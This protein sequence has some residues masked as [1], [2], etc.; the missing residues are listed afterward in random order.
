LIPVLFKWDNEIPVTSA[1]KTTTREKSRD[2]KDECV[3][4]FFDIFNSST[5]DVT[6]FLIEEDVSVSQTRF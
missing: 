6:W 1:A 3:N 4:P 5:H 2:T